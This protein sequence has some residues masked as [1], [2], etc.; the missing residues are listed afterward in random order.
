MCL[1][2]IPQTRPLATTHSSTFPA[3]DGRGAVQTA[4]TR[5]LQSLGEEAAPVVLLCS[6]QERVVRTL[7]DRCHRWEAPRAVTHAL[8]TGGAWPLPLRPYSQGGASVGLEERGGV[9]A[10][11]WLAFSTQGKSVTRTQKS[12]VRLADK[13]PV[14]DAAAPTHKHPSRSADSTTVGGAEAGGPS[15][16]ALSPTFAGRRPEAGPQAKQGGTPAATTNKDAPGS[17][18]TSLADSETARSALA[19]LVA[20][21]CTW[22]TH[23]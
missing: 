13:S 16:E 6:S 14:W 19:R 1:H 7:R 3:C 17:K 18:E 21:N 12:R 5:T 8:A 2:Q 11:E 10:L 20:Q 15:S 4:V 22:L 23:R 9:P